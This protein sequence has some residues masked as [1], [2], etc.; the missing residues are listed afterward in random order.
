MFQP[1]ATVWETTILFHTGKSR[2]I[3]QGRGRSILF[4]A[5]ECIISG[6][7]ECITSDRVMLCFKPGRSALFLS[8]EWIISG[9]GVHYFFLGNGSG[10]GGVHCFFL[11]NGLFQ[12]GECMFPAGKWIVSG[13]KVH[14]YGSESASVV[15]SWGLHFLEHRSY[16]FQA[17]ESTS[18]GFGRGVL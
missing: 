6:R 4:Q 3:L 7:E 18:S 13:R 17:R 15:S 16:L 10:W 11:G 2:E 9:R 12:A 5:A 8:G 14:C 1:P